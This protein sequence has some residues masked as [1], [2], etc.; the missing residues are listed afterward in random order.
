MGKVNVRLLKIAD[1][2]AS[3]HTLN[4]Q[5]FP[6]DYL[7]LG[8]YIVLGDENF[9]KER[10]DLKIAWKEDIKKKTMKQISSNAYIQQN[11]LRTKINGTGSKG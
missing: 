4:K 1:F 3:A 8:H 10:L 9:K 5:S 7:Y 11:F 6:Q 2:W